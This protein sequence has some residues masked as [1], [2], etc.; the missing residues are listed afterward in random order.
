[1]V[2]TRVH[3]GSDVE[4]LLGIPVMGHFPAIERS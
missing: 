1:M 4:E 3:S 2:D